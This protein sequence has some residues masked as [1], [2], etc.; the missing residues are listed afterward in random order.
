MSETLLKNVNELLNE[1]KWTRATLNSYTISHFQELDTRIR[2]TI[3]AE[4]QDKVLEMCEEHLKHTRNS[5]IALYLSGII[6]LGKQLVDDSNLVVLINIFVDNHKWNI[7]E[8]LCNRILEYGEN[9][10]A[11]KTLADCYENKNDQEQKFRIWERYIKVD[12]EDADIV[13]LLAE[14]KEQDG[15]LPNSI[16]YYKKALHRFI[17][18]KM[19]SNV[20]EI[21]EK[22]IAYI[23]DDVDFFFAIERKIVKVLNGE[24]AAALLNY[25]VPHFLKKED[26]NTTI[27][28]LKRILAYEPKNAAA[29]KQIVE[30]FRNKYV[31]H[32]QL[33]EYLRIS[34]LSQSWRSVHEAISDFEKHIAFDVGNYVYHSSWKIGKIV[35]IKDDMFIID[36][37]GKAGHKMSLKMAVNALKILSPEHIWVLS[38]TMPKEELKSRIKADHAWALKVIIRSFNNAADMKLIKEQLTPDIL[39]NSE[40][41]KWSSEARRLLRT[42]SAFGNIPDKLDRFTVRDKPIPFEEKTYNKFKAEKNFFDRVQTIREFLDNVEPDSDYFSE[43]LGYFTGFLKSFSTLSEYTVAS[44]LLV[45]RIV[46]VFPYLNPGLDFTFVDLMK[47]INNY[48]EMFVKLDDGEIKR[49]F[50]QHVKLYHPQWP[51]IYAELF[52]HYQNKFIIDELVKHESWEILRGLIG[53]IMS[54]YREYRESFVWVVRNLLTEPWFATMEVRLEKVL[55]GMI[56]LLDIT[57]REINNKRDVSYNR[58]IN[59]QAHDFLFNEGRLLNYILESGE[60]SIM[61]LYTL[62]EDIKELDPNLKIN[63]KHQIRER[64]PRYEFAGDQEKEKVSMGLLVTRRGYEG[65]QK[66]LRHILENEIPE[67]S[68]EIGFALS[69]GDLR[70]NSEYKAALEKQELLKTTASRLQEEL[71][72]AQIFSAAPINTD[73]VSFGTRVILKNLESGG[74]ELYTL[75]GPWESDPV[76]NIIS[77]RS[78][79]GV[80]LMNHKVGEE[81]KFAIGDRNF[82]YALKAIERTEVE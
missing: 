38:S 53:Q 31:K 18:K 81:L 61:R 2:E 78:P 17:N 41:S 56:H 70:E 13:K 68:K 75:L 43:M 46:S 76:K 20:K 4:A 62:V 30:A 6:S 19:F 52:H 74:E 39:S 9:K 26:W 69:K 7:V 49:S 33:E 50:L 71:Q 66:E 12:Y 79:L 1:E 51:Q 32:S 29:R 36:F 44:F 25:L 59:K 27:E 55:I 34:N 40:W 37:A 10:F 16:E 42:D 23:P 73:V 24:R 3:Q 80:E 58:K 63:F 77:Y 72:N 28:L 48:E 35:S 60:D 5:I 54:R 82:H 11:L 15:D 47:E 67:N 14:K 65:K 8:F 45:Q 57:F 22:L 21:W 64:Y